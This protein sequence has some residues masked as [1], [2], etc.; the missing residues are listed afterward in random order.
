MRPTTRST[1]A[2]LLRTLR[3]TRL[4]LAFAATFLGVAAIPAGAATIVVTSPDDSDMGAIDTCTL[5]QAILSM[6]IGGLVAACHK[7]GAFGV[8]DT[9]TFAVSAVSGAA[10]P[11]TVTLTDSADPDGGLG[12]TLVVSA[13]RLTIDGSDW[14]GDGDGQYPDGVTIARPEGA[15]H[16]FGILRGTAPA[17]G[18][19]VLKGVAIR[20]GYAFAGDGGGIG[21]DAADLTMSDSRVSGNR[22][23]VGGGVSSQS[24]DLTFTRCTIDGNV[25]YLGGGVHSA[26]GTVTLTASTI[27]GNGEWGS[28]SGGG[29]RADGTLVVTDSTISGNS[30]MH[31]AGIESAGEL[32]L[33]GSVVAGNEAYMYGGGL[34]VR[35]GGNATVTGSTLSGNSA[36]Y[37]GGGAYAQGSLTVA[38]STIA[39]NFVFR[40]GGGI[41][42]Y[43]GGTL[44]LDHATL[45]RNH[46]GA[47]GGGVGYT[48]TGVPW[49]GSATIDH[50]IVSDNEQAS[51][52][53]VDLRDSW[54]GVGNLVS[55][56][57]ANL[58]PLQDNGG[59]TPTMLPGAG[60]AAIDAI[61]PPD[62]TQSADQ[63]GIGRPQGAGCDV[64]AV[65]V[66]VDA[67]FADG[68]DDESPPPPHEGPS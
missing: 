1:S 52:T 43:G 37:N 18:L 2:A 9:I 50:S 7:T 31:G 56:P 67:I 51:G 29:I 28:S 38:N 63:R 4:H 55:S 35:A 14:R 44:R 6:D 40:D 3:R 59:P 17:G 26:S 21:M 32:S 16:K 13:A 34:H 20:N 47:T 8:D 30:G 62:C 57:H 65:E 24:G 48:E 39:G 36:R 53:D 10:T 60:S 68:F 66:F 25:G 41:A 45:A 22:A 49:T 11:G 19:L 12:G 27:S 54:S 46:A 5:R 61:A 58:G 23:N 33:I 42:L 64:G 15:T